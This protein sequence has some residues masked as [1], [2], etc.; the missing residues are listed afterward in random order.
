[1]EMYT[2]IYENTIGDLINLTWLGYGVTEASEKM[3]LTDEFT[4]LSLKKREVL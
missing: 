2:W 3:F 1:M 4:I